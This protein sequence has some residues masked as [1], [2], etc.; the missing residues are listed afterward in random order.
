MWSDTDFIY[1][2]LLAAS[3]VGLAEPLTAEEG[4]APAPY[5]PCGRWTDLREH[6]RTLGQS[7][8]LALVVV[9]SLG[10][11]RRGAADHRRL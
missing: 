5:G 8:V 2:A 1:D 4:V 6:C 10:S 3:L 7:A 9:V 11:G